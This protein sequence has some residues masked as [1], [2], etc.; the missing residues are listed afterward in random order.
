MRNYKNNRRRFRK[1]SFDRSLKINSNDQ[2]LNSNIGNISDFKKKA[3]EEIALIPQ[4]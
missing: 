2:T 1:N 4:N 3:L